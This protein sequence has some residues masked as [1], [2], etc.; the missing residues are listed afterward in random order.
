[1][2]IRSPFPDVGIPAQDVTAFYF[3]LAQK[4]EISSKCGS[5]SDVPLII[6]DATKE[7]CSFSDIKQLSATVAQ[8][9]V[10][11]GLDI[12]Y[13]QSH[14][15]RFFTGHVGAILLRTDIRLSA[16]HFGILLA[17][18][19]VA[20]MDPDQS[21][22]VLGERLKV[23]NANSVFVAADLLPLLL[24]A[25]DQAGYHVP[26]SRIFVLDAFCCDKPVTDNEC[27]LFDDFVAANSDAQYK[28]PE[29]MPE[30]ELA[31]KVA[32]IVYSSGTTGS[33]KGVMLTH[34]NLV[35]AQMMVNG[36]IAQNPISVTKDG[37]PSYA[38]E[39]ILAALPPWHLFGFSVQVYQPLATGC[40]LV[41]LPVLDPFSYIQAIERYRIGRLCATPGTL[42]ALVSNSHR[43]KE[44]GRITVTA[45][46][47]QSYD[48][49]S[50]RA[51][52]CGGASIP[53]ARKKQYRE[54][55]GNPVFA[56]G[57]GATET[58]SII[59]GCTLRKP[60]P[61]AVGVL[62]PNSIAK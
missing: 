14:C 17:G 52:V 8:G 22:S 47:E 30:E 51:I 20:A 60:T 49:S 44:S 61:G 35:A 10:A 58:S 6:N 26:K 53:P 39:S 48:I 1:M 57:Y 16:I 11:T 36:Y 19:T 54:F 31:R 15:D 38:R 62:Y 3:G 56:I 55:F 18:G 33:A 2:P 59:A 32:L 5:A 7:Q 37:I 43:S 25:L 9:L 45:V 29:P 12:R 50:V 21:P 24:S 27:V 23:I 41:V 34:R 40:Y 46:A 13:R 28:P 4:R 42:H